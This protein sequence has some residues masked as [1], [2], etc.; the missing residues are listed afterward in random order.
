MAALATVGAAPCCYQVRS[1]SGLKVKRPSRHILDSVSPQLLESSGTWRMP[2]M[3]EGYEGCGSAE[4]GP[5][6]G[7]VSRR[8]QQRV[9]RWCGGW[10]VSVCVRAPVCWEWV[11]ACAQ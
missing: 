5:I 7:V 11:N 6:G 1:T 4:A 8:C 2:A 3:Y 10:R 9:L